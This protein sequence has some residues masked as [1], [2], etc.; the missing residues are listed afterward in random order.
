MPMFD[1]D[2]D[3]TGLTLTIPSWTG[4]IQRIQT[5][6]DLSLISSTARLALVR[7]LH[8]LIDK[9]GEMLRILEEE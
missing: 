9:T 2:A 4:S 1:P 6:T 3:I 7:E 5:K 8:I